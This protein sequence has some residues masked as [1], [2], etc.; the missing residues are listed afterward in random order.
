MNSRISDIYS[1]TKV[2][3]FFQF[4]SP[5]AGVLLF[6]VRDFHSLLFL[7]GFYGTITGSKTSTYG[8]VSE[9]SHG[10]IAWVASINSALDKFTFFWTALYLYIVHGN[11]YDIIIITLVF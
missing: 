7:Y 9:L 11:V 6:Y 1:R 5:L 10:G 3:T 8:L 2:F 4:L